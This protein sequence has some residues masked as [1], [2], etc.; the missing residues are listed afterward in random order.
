MN[1]LHSAFQCAMRSHAKPKYHFTLHPWRTCGSAQVNGEEI[2]LAGL[3]FQERRELKV[4]AKIEI[5]QGMAVSYQGMRGS[6]TVTSTATS[7]QLCVW[8]LW[9]F[10]G[11]SAPRSFTNYLD[12]HLSKTGSGIGCQ[13]KLFWAGLPHGGT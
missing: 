11:H 5:P 2:H 12:F 7:S 6:S 3:V 9:P 8:L 4:R 10:S 1:H 13:K